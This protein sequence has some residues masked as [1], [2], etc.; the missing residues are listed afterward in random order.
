MS[1]RERFGSVTLV[2]NLSASSPELLGDLIRLLLQLHG[3]AFGGLVIHGFGFLCARGLGAS[4]DCRWGADSPAL[5]AK[6][7]QST[8]HGAAMR[9]RA[10]ADGGGHGDGNGGCEDSRW[11]PVGVPATW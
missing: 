7:A 1:S 11:S 9:G 8:Q 6:V 3:L 10:D 5:A 4:I 2:C